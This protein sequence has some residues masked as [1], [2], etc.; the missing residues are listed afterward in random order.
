[1]NK[2]KH[3][4]TLCL[5]GICLV[6]TT[7]NHIL[8]YIFIILKTCRKT[9]AW[10]C[11]K[12]WTQAKKN[13]M[14]QMYLRLLVKNFSCGVSVFLSETQQM[15]SEL[16]EQKDNFLYCFGR[17]RTVVPLFKEWTLILMC[18]WLCV[19]H[20]FKTKAH[21]HFFIIVCSLK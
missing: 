2:L 14:M 19:Q 1:M 9:F 15:S 5:D 18:L 8:G 3:K 16:L 13:K 11:E 21:P 6:C 7:E 17:C 4:R 12:N 10:W 20:M